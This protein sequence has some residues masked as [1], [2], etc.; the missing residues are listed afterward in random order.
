MHSSSQ[1]PRRIYP[2]GVCGAFVVSGTDASSTLPS[3]K[4][5]RWPALLR[6]VGMA[7]SGVGAI[8]LSNDPDEV[9][10]RAC[11]WWLASEPSSTECP[12][13][14]GALVS[15]RVLEFLVGIFVVLL[16]WPVITWA[17]NRLNGLTKEYRFRSPW[18]RRLP[19]S[20]A[21]EIATH[22]TKAIRHYSP[23]DRDRISDALAE[24]SELFNSEVVQLHQTGATILKEW[25]EMRDESIIIPKINPYIE[26]ANSIHQELDRVMN[27]YKVYDD[28]LDVVISINKESQLGKVITRAKDFDQKLQVIRAR[29][30]NPLPSSQMMREMTPILR[31]EDV[32][33]LVEP[34]DNFFAEANNELKVWVQAVNQRIDG[35]K[36]AI[37]RADN[38]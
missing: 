15:F 4:P 3:P 26:K 35:T 2:L 17:F 6:L 36:S 24:I 7:V 16:V 18:E 20:L 14:I 38:P 37:L 31:K 19:V 27:K 28:V 1:S 22:P 33:R 10:R 9:R 25:H 12:E 34:V 8:M 21:V 13:W 29:I 32:A 23:G 5:M 30:P 11:D